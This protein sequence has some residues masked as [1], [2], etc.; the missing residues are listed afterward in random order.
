MSTCQAF[1]LQVPSSVKHNVH[2]SKSYW[3][4][5]NKRN[6]ARQRSSPFLSRHGR[7]GRGKEVKNHRL[8]LDMRACTCV[9]AS[10]A[11]LSLLG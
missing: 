2:Q 1:A 3:H 10:F 4:V 5:R 11:W 9:T 7:V 8:E 6:D